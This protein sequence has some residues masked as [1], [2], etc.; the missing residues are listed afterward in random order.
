MMTMASRVVGVF[1]VDSASVS[2]G[3]CST[4]FSVYASD[5]RVASKDSTAAREAIRAATTCLSI[6]LQR[7]GG[8]CQRKRKRRRLCRQ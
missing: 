6:A 4:A 5:G 8:Q 7:R 3:D 1:S 2:T